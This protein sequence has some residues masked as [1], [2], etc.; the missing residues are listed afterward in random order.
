[1]G[2]VAIFIGQFLWWINLKK[3]KLKKIVLKLH[4]LNAAIFLKHGNGSEKV[5][6]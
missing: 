6:M 4:L 3:K 2:F 1:M 5:Y